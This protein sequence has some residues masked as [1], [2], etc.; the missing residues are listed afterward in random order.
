MTDNR[1]D[2]IFNTLNIQEK[3]ELLSRLL[4][5]LMEDTMT[6][7]EAAFYFC[8]IARGATHKE[9]AREFNSTTEAVKSA[10]YKAR[11]EVNKARKKVK[12]I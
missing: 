11:K 5:P 3:A 4:G 7:R 1:I 8:Y 9:I 12:S 6:H 10:I 2:E